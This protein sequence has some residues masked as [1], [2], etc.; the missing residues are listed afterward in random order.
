MF[1]KC[2][3]CGEH[4]LLQATKCEHCGC[5]LG[6]QTSINPTTVKTGIVNSPTTSGNSIEQLE[7]LAALK[8]RGVLSDEE[9]QQQKRQIL[10]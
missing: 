10:G 6:K 8:E 4:N 1:N 7:R 5:L 9:F 2:P 3:K